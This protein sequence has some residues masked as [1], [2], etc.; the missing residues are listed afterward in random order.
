MFL[1]IKTFLKK[2]SVTFLIFTTLVK[3]FLSKPCVD[4]S[5]I[6]STFMSSVWLNLAK[7]QANA[8]QNPKDEL[9]LFENSSHSSCYQP[10]IIGYILKNKQKV[11]WIQT[12]QIIRLIIMLKM[13][14]KTKNTS[15]RYCINRPAITFITFCDF[16]MFYQIFLSPQAKRSVIINNKHGIFQ[17][18]HELPNDL[19]LRTFGNQEKSGK[20][21]NFIELKLNAKFSSRNKN[22]VDTC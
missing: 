14:T 8:K 11:R 3:V 7:N 6:S 19:R 2:I 10:K 20:S 18:A 4:Y 13:M 21:Q 22:V 1:D 17:L 16:L 15:H 12:H 5:F 9:F